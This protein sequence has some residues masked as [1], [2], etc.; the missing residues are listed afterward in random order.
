MHAP[1]NHTVLYLNLQT[2][3][4]T[5]LLFAG[6]YGLRSCVC[7]GK[8]SVFISVHQFEEI[9]SAQQWIARQASFRR[10]FFSLCVRLLSKRHRQIQVF[11]WEP[12][13]TGHHCAF[14]RGRRERAGIAG[15]EGGRGDNNQGLQAQITF[16]NFI[17][18]KSGFKPTSSPYQ[19]PPPFLL[20][21]SG[22]QCKLILQ[23]LGGLICSQ[24]CLLGWI[25]SETN[26]GTATTL[27]TIPAHQL[28]SHF[29][30]EIL[31]AMR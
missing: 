2:T 10:L 1:L 19:H 29:S 16:I 18:S 13:R 24:L 3:P 5:P 20:H 9:F 25:F 14:L 8:L 17:N 23:T 27:P 26:T 30:V 21:K 6:L 4:S 12:T 31:K 15:I 22:F 11:R 7:R 28:R